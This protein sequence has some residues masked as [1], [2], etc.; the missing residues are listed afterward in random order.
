MEEE[1]E[2]KPA[3]KAWSDGL[4]SAASCCIVVVTPHVR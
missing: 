4:N 2:G 3:A 1:F